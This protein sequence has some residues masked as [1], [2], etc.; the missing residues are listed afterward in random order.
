MQFNSYIFLLIYLPILVSG[1]FITNKLNNTFGKIWL[2]IGCAVFYIYGGWANTI[3]LG[4]SIALNLLFAW[5]MTRTDKWKKW[6]LSTDLLANV[7][8]LFYYKYFNFFLSNLNTIFK[9]DYPS[10]KILLP[11]GISFFT[12]QQ[13]MYI[14]AVYRTEISRINLSDYLLSILYFPKLIMGPL[15][16]P[17]ALIAQLNDS[18]LKKVDW[19]HISHGLKLLSFGLFKK[20]ILA[21]TFAKAV[22]WGFTN[23]ES[24]TSMDCFLVMLFYTFEIYF[25]FSGYSDMAVGISVMLNIKLPINFDSPYKAL[26]IRD[27]WKRWHISLTGFLTKYIYIP[28]GGSKKGI[29]RTYIN[30]LLVFLISGIWHGANWTFILWGILHGL[31]SVLDRV[32]EKQKKNLSETVRWMGTFFAI[33]LLWLLFRSDSITQWLT[34]LQKMFTFENMAVSGGL[35]AT[36]VLPEAKFLFQLFRLEALNTAVRGFSLLLFTLGSLGLCLIPANNYRRLEENNWLTMILA[37]IAF[38]WS[39]LC[40]SSESV[41]VY[42]NF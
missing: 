16:E 42:F 13:I 36:F 29:L 10:Q 12:F 22:S 38:V 8:L 24:A 14:V 20:L 11:L 34:I 30:T 17:G 15:M 1:Y 5:L 27:F 25:D 26:S 40:L 6:L 23:L 41:F 19:D 39:F 7:A 28:L 18:N 4:L 9:T 31:L 21:D 3:I 33:N 32:F 35:I 37:A 2:T